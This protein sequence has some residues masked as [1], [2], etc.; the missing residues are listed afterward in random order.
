MTPDHEEELFVHLISFRG[1][2]GDVK[3]LVSWADSV[4]EAEEYSDVVADVSLLGAK[5]NKEVLNHLESIDPRGDY[6]VAVDR[7]LPKLAKLI[8][9]DSEQLKLVCKYLSEVHEEAESQLPD[10][11]EFM[12][13][14]DDDYFIAREGYTDLTV[15]GLRGRVLQD[16]ERVR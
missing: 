8:E 9:S 7:L 16:I 15:D 3:E 10:K 13:R 1:K 14:A 12:G 2:V 11:Y 6:V 5:S 4:I